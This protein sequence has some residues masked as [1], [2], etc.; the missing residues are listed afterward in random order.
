MTV[1]FNLSILR[2]P[3]SEHCEK[4]IINIFGV[5]ERAKFLRGIHTK[6]MTYT[7]GESVSSPKVPTSRFYYIYWREY[8]LSLHASANRKVCYRTFR[9]L[10]VRI[11]LTVMTLSD[12]YLFLQT[13]ESTA[14]RLFSY[15]RRH[16]NNY[17]ELLLHC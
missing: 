8:G 16:V 14:Q 1:S 7:C 15:S 3:A 12:V 13:G 2:N 11:Y 9:S 4:H 6:S 17:S 5:F 10:F